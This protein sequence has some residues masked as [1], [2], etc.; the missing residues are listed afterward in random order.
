MWIRNSRYAYDCE[1]DHYG[2][3]A[4]EEAQG[5]LLSSLDFGSSE[6]DQGNADDFEKM[7]SVNIRFSLQKVERL[8]Q[9]IGE[10]IQR[11]GQP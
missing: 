4:E 8:T 9:Y 7:N 6:D 11:V 5:E 3:E 10:H 2:G 1:C